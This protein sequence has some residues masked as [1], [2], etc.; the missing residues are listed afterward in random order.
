[1][2]KLLLAFAATAMLGGCSTTFNETAPLPKGPEALVASRAP[3]GMM[4]CVASQLTPEQRKTSFGVIEVADR[5]GV[6]NSS[7]PDGFGYLNTQGA[8]DMLVSSMGKFGIR[9]VE[10][11]PAYRAA[12]DWM[13]GKTGVGLTGDGTEYVGMGA[14]GQRVVSRN[15]P[16]VKGTVAPM[17][18]GIYGAITASDPL[19][20]GG[21]KVGILGASLGGSQNRIQQRIDLRAVR[22][23]VGTTI[24]GEVIATTTIEKQV[25]Q[26]SVELNL[27]RYFDIGESPTLVTVEAGSARREPLKF[28]TGAMLDLAMADLLTQIYGLG[29]T[30]VQSAPRT[31]VA[32]AF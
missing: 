32:G 2:K 16:L 4:A 26:D 5:T 8:G 14:G 1:M 29:C 25:V 12:L 27:T 15:T 30:P 21:A 9:I 6:V 17:E 11:G 20:G 19:P 7:G 22:M 31:M 28:S 18:I 10:V 24:G 3:I 13:L 23:T